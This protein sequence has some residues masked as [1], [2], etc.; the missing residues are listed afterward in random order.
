MKNPLAQWL[1]ILRWAPQY[2]AEHFAADGV[3]AAVVTLML[4]P[5]SL[6]YALLAGM[7]AQTGLYASMLP[8]VA[9]AIFGTSNTLAV[10]PAAITSIMTASALGSMALA[11]S[12][13]YVA[14]VALLTL[15][16]GLMLFLMGVLRL[17]V[18]AN[19]LSHPVISGFVS[20]SGLLIAASQLKHLL[21]IPI[22]GQTLPQ[23]TGSLVQHI[24]QWQTP[25][26]AI[27]LG[28]LVFLVWARRSFKPRLYALG[29]QPMAADI[30]A[31]AAPVIALAVATL[32]AWALHL[33]EQGLRVVG[34]VPGGLPPLTL[35][36]V[37]ANLWPQ[38]QQLATAALL[39]SLVGFVESVSLGQS[40]AAKRRERIEPD[41]E[42]RGLGAANIAAGLTGGFPVT[43]GFSRSV[44]NFDAGA[45]T[46]AAGMYTAVGLLLAALLLTPLLY[47]LPQTA[48]AATIVASVL[49][50][51]DLPAFTRTWRYARTDFTALALTF[52]LTLLVGIEAGL[53]AGVG[54]SLLLHLWRTSRPHIATVGRV[55]GTEH[56]R[57]VLRHAVET[58]PKL[59]SIRVDESLYFANARPLEDHIATQVAAHPQLEHVVLQ[60]NAI[61]AIDA[62]A[63]ES[64]EAIMLRLKDAG[65]KLHLSEVKGPVMDRL[66]RSDFLQH[67]TGQVFLT[68]HQ[69]VTALTQASV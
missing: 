44:V 61:N 21:G 40:L 67:L 12:V 2:R 38:V 24:G 22:Q 45:R 14:A 32:V 50:L 63:L 6:A 64:L 60:C 19:F 43:G 35:P 1:P 42:L 62:S 10:G 28:T 68:H 11:G 53:M 37:D 66:Q 16:S 7:P 20:A 36:T 17:G 8:L 26:A 49:T 29:L 13:G 15:M 65:V 46:P 52:A 5:Q 39:I 41:A 33:E 30:V 23:L 3:A 56:Y 4:I 34:A 31:K 47:H 18:I 55:P 9:Y 51:V 54:A 25:A 27:G 69:A 58:H 57:N 48:L 59:L